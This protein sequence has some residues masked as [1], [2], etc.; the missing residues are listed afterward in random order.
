[1]IVIFAS[2]YDT[3]ATS[4]AARWAAHNAGLLTCDD[5]SVVGWRHYLSSEEASTAV[6]GGRVVSVEEISGVFVRW[7]GVF[8]QEL[9][10]IAAADRNYVAGEM[11]AFLVSWLSS[12]R[13]PVINRPTPLNLT[14]PAWRLEQWTYA[15]AQ[16]GI[17]VRPVH[18]HITINFDNGA[19]DLHPNPA[20]VTVVG[21]R[22]FGT[23]DE[24]LR[25]QARRLAEAAGV[26]LLKISFSGPEAGSFFIS[27]DLIPDISDEVAD[28]MLELLL[29]DEG[30]FS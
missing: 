22:C 27:A 23:V 17:P 16:Q 18:R 20:T 2:R 28:A 25:K 3:S 21:E 7:P 15:A 19:E 26:P 9:T 8:A 11:L 5:L 30:N 24:Q 13:C 14:G 29:E 1:M 10:Q 6:I 4:L 12:L